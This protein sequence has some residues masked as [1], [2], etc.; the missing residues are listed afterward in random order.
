MTNAHNI[1]INADDLEI[2]ENDG[3]AVCSHCNI[4]CQHGTYTNLGSEHGPT[5]SLCDGCL[6]DLSD[7]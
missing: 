4:L 5:V 6:R 1:N 2:L 7:A 3:W